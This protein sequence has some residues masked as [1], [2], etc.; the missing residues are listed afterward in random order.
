[1]RR[2][3]RRKARNPA[4]MPEGFAGHVALLAAFLGVM[5]IGAAVNDKHRPPPSQ[6]QESVTAGP[7]GTR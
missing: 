5:L 1:M 3:I 4:R 2:T 6:A 7:G